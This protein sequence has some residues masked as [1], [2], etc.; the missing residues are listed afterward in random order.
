MNDAGLRL[1]FR[2]VYV[3]SDSL[4]STRTVRTVQQG[5][6]PWLWRSVCRAWP[7]FQVWTQESV[8]ALAALLQELGSRQVL[9]VGAGDGRLTR[10]L[11]AEGRSRGFAVTGQD[12]GSWGQA[13][14]GSELRHPVAPLRQ[15]DYRASLAA[16]QP[17]T[18]VVSWMPYEEDWTPAFRACPAV[19]SYLLIGEDNGG[20][21]G[22]DSQWTPGPGWTLQEVEAFRHVSCS[23]LDASPT[24]GATGLWLARRPA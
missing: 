8:A 16:V 19:R 17:D 24:W 6:G 3:D 1:W 5:S 21:T 13:L 9:E 11:Q 23:S 14:P 12:D 4:P 10:A 15:E 22:A 20:C 2:Q 18:V 7:V